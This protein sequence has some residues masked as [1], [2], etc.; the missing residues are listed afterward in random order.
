MITDNLEQN[1]LKIDLDENGVVWGHNFSYITNIIYPSAEDSLL[2]Y[3]NSY[4][5]YIKDQRELHAAFPEEK[6][7]ITLMQERILGYTEL[8]KHCIEQTIEIH[9]SNI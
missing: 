4:I 9:K 6:E 5:D 3:I 8:L 2:Y 1:K 7:P